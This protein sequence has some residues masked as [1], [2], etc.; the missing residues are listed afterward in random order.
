[1]DWNSG[2]KNGMDY[3]ETFF[4][5]HYWAGLCGYLLSNL[6]I[7]SSTSYWSAFMHHFHNFEVVLVFS[8][9]T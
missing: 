8:V 9:F 2:T 3:G 1:M 7:A 5:W 4:P 6:L